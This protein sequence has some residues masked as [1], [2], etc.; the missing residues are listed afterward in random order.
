MNVLVTGG[1]GFV[2]NVLVDMCRARGD[3]IT[4]VTRDPKNVKAPRNDAMYERWLPDLAPFDAIVHLMGESVA[5]KRW[6]DEQKEKLR[7]SRIPTTRALVEA[8]GKSAR[9]PPV[10]VCAS[11]VGYYGSRGD[12]ILAESAPPGHGFLADLCV[13]WEQAAARASNHGVRVVSM[14]TGIVLGRSGGALKTM[15]PL[16]K[17]GLGGPLG[18]G[19]AWFPWIHV[20]D[21]AALF[22]FV[23]DTSA[24]HGPI[25]G[26]AP[27]IVREEDFA[28]ALGR[29]LHRPAFVSAPEFALRLALG[30]VV[31]ALL[32]S[33]RCV[34]ARALT[35]GFEFEHPDLEPTLHHILDPE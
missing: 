28:Q 2:G 35:L 26:V 17:F 9:K 12:E 8:I 6:T 14:R 18:T 27:G 15:L 23:I 22:L 11:A 33:A 7:S 1:T 25:N 31:T 4:I 32:A 10:F 30:E 13:E 21:L 3:S 16:F 19:D 34:P 29:V 20:N 5:G 24:A